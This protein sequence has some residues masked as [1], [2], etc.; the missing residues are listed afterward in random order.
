MRWEECSL[1]RAGAHLRLKIRNT[2]RRHTETE[3]IFGVHGDPN[4]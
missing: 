4:V 2:L 3:K 1:A